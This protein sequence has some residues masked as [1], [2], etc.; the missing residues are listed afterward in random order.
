MTGSFVVIKKHI[1]HQI[2]I[3]KNT[4]IPYNKYR[5]KNNGF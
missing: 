4:P 2:F 5:C 1:F 3:E